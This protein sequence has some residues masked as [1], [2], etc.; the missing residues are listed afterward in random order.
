MLPKLRKMGDHYEL[1]LEHENVKYDVWKVDTSGNLVSSIKAKLWEDEQKFNLDLNGDGDTGLQL[2]EAIGNVHLKHGDNTYNGAP[3]YYIVDGNN[4]PIGLTNAGASSGP[5]SVVGWSATQVIANESEGYEVLWTNPSSN[6]YD[7]WKVDTSGNLVS[8]IKAKLWEDEQKFNL[9]L[10]GDGDT[11]LQ[12][13]EAI[14]NVHLKHG[15]NTYNGAP[16]Y[17]IVDGNNDPIGLTNAGASSGPASVVGWS[18]TQVIANESEGYEVL[19]TNPS[20]NKYDVWKVDT[21]GNLVSS[22]KAKLW[23]DEQ[24]F[25]LDLNG[26]GDTGLQLVE[27]I[28]N[29]HLKHGDNTY[30]GA[31]QYYIVDGNNDPIGL[32]NAGASSGPASVVGWS[33]TQVIANE[34]EGYE[35]LWTNP[36][37]NKYDVWKVDTSGNLVSSIKAKLWEDEQKF[38]LDLNG[39]GDTGLQLVE[40][41]GNVHLKHGDNTYNGAPQYYIVDGNNDPIGLTNAGASS[42]PASVVGWS[43]TQVIANESEGYEVLWT[44]PSSNKYDVWKVD[45]SGNLVSSIKAKLW[46]DEL[47]FNLDLNGDGDTGLQLVEAIGNVHLKHGDN[48]YNGAP[49]YY[50]VDGN[51]DPIGLTNAGASSGPASVV[52]WSATQ[53][54]ANE[55]EGYE[56]LWTNPSSNKYDVW[57]VDTSGNLVSSIKAKLWEDELKFNLDLNGDG[58]TGLQQ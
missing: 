43:A 3:Q 11:G 2:V 15:D 39:D 5:A 1:L 22:I 57:K 54:I 19:W 41:I 10:N 34:S 30:N 38:N 27:A 36:S 12:L 48:T 46:E 51:N 35:V 29:V 47:K 24:K 9:D 44:N 53:V 4:D 33:A 40:A 50:I 55:S 21:S 37:S 49:Q 13:V 45:T 6:K 42:G 14:G 32:T 7:V 18:A 56:V 31:P 17:Y 23:E 20:S 8:S 52:G 58:D 25:N 28:G 26:D 16:Q